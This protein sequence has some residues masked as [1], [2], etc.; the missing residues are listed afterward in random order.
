M[1]SF[2]ACLEDMIIGLSSGAV[3]LVKSSP[4]NVMLIVSRTVREENFLGLW[5]WSFSNYRE[6][7]IPEKRLSPY[8]AAANFACT[9]VSFAFTEPVPILFKKKVVKQYL[10]KDKI[11][12][13]CRRVVNLSIEPTFLSPVGAQTAFWGLHCISRRV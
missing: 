8:I 11:E 5:E 2:S 10:K 4:E 12:Y 1:L 3:H 9:I 6:V 7:I 13:M